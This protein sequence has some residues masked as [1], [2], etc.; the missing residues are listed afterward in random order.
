MQ[1]LECPPQDY[2]L[3][4]KSEMIQKTLLQRL[5]V[6]LISKSLVFIRLLVFR[7]VCRLISVCDCWGKHQSRSQGS[8]DGGVRPHIWVKWRKWVE[9]STAY[10]SMSAL[11]SALVSYV[12]VVT[13]AH[14]AH[15]VFLV[16][17]C[18]CVSVCAYAP[19]YTQ[20]KPST[21]AGAG[22]GTSSAAALARPLTPFFF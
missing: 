21:G 9:K 18:T 5:L 1:N 8:G 12:Y 11:L 17:R 7:S 6:H 13:T 15:E 16:C 14:L 10:A 20:E 2:Y 3:K 22:P 19:A 4:R